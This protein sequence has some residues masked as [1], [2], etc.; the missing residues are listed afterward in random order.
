MRSVW[1]H[2]SLTIDPHSIRRF[3]TF[4]DIE[5]VERSIAVSPEFTVPGDKN[6]DLSCQGLVQVDLLNQYED[7]ACVQ[8]PSRTR[9]WEATDCIT[10]HNTLI[11]DEDPKETPP[12][13]SVAFTGS[14]L[15]TPPSPEGIPVPWESPIPYV[16]ATW[17]VILILVYIA[18]FLF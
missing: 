10:V 17:V 14:D 3:V 11:A 13:P 4:P 16:A 9:D 5:G 7:C 18:T 8:L 6:N 12:P 1:L 15:D 2:C